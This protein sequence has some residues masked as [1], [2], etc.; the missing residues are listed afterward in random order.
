MNLLPFKV[1]GT[2][3]EIRDDVFIAIKRSK[4]EIRGSGMGLLLDRVKV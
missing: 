4:A 2:G 3:S 1:P